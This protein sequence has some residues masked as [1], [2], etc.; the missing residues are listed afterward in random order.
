MRLLLVCVFCLA[1]AIPARAELT[2]KEVG[3]IAMATS[4]DSRKLAEHYAEARGIPKG[5]VLLLEGKPSQVISRAVWEDEMRPAVRSW[6]S[7]DSRRGRIRCLVTCWDVPLK[8]DR[9]AADSDDVVARKEGLSKARANRVEQLGR[10]IT[11]L[12]GLGRSEKPQPVV[13]AADISLKELSGKLD[14]ALK[15]AQ[16]RIGGLQSEEEKKEG[17]AKFERLFLAAGG[18]SALMRM[19]AGR[20]K[21]RQFTTEQNTR[22]AL[23]QG[24]LQ[25]LQQGLQ[26]L[27]A[28]PDSDTR[29]VQILN[30]IQA[31]N[32]LVGATQW[33]DQQLQLLGKNE[34]YSS[35]DSEL[36]LVLWPEYPLFRWHPNPLHYRFDSIPF[37]RPTM[38]VS[39]LA[40]PTL[41]LAMGLVDAALAVEKT[42]LAGK[43]YIDARGMKFDPQQD[44]PGSYG[45]YDESLRDLAERLKKHT[46]LEVVV[47]NEAKL[48]QPGDCPDAALYC[49]W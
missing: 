19:A 9:R 24:R 46:K 41:E 14:A 16:Q 44:K 28:L 25:G 7:E 31:T 32:G 27:S 1:M 40:A 49:G 20:L 29:D 39:R 45:Q 36:S 26:A 43:V 4:T 30:L 47:N 12:D 3:I 10:L 6:L 8:I 22:L 11:L 23:L 15:S 37:K 38:M 13:L 33:I 21:D 48:F 34:T 35:F 18:S 17:G 42:G 2:P 5:Q